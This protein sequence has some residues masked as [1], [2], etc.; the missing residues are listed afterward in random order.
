MGGRLG[1]S[2]FSRMTYGLMYMRV[3]RLTS[4]QNVTTKT[5]CH[6][7]VSPRAD[8]IYGL[9]AVHVED[10]LAHSCAMAAA[11]D[12]MALTNMILPQSTAAVRRSVGST[13]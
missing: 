3:V 11:E 9:S 5:K 6:R 13:R 12:S 8:A 10:A 7:S 4:S 1:A 2:M